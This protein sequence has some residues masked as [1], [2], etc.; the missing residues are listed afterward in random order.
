MSI[1]IKSATPLF[2]LANGTPSYTF[3][4]SHQYALEKQN[5]IKQRQFLQSR[6]MNTSTT[7]GLLFHALANR[8]GFSLIRLGDSELLVLA[9]DLLFPTSIPISQWGVLMAILCCDPDLGQGDD[10]VNRWENIVRVSGNQYPDHKAQEYL[11][12]ALR[13]ATLI[14]IPHAYRPGRSVEHVK[15][16][17]GFQTVFLHLLQKL[18][19]PLN[20]LKLTDSAEHHLL[21]AS[22]WL[23]RLLVPNQYPELGQYYGLS[24]EYQP[25]ILLAGNLAAPFASLLAHEGCHVVAAIQPVGMYNIEEVI[26][27]IRQHSF[28]LAL[29]S[30]GTAAKYICTSIARQM[31]KVALD[32]GQ[33]FDT[34]LNQYGHLNHE[35]Y[36]IPMMTFM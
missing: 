36:I 5:V 35:H 2:T 25:R 4:A 15:L 26:H 8:Q 31:G 34:L 22:G 19:I 13:S 24:P 3:H 30:A 28:D 21:H 20:S 1:N 18:N 7:A 12:K 33:L 17:E 27:Q 29:I 6:I 9:Q 16:L 10:E 32:T 23:R 14:G 11:I